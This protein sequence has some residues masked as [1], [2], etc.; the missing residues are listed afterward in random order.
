MLKLLPDW[1]RRSPL[2]QVTCFTFVGLFLFEL[3]KELLAPELT[4]WQSHSLT[5]AIGTLVATLGGALVL[6]RLQ[7]MHQKVLILQ[8]P[9]RKNAQEGGGR[10]F[11]LVRE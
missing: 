7:R 3:S 11:D 5:I 1:L 4:K 6:S 8:T 10:L 2:L 9:S